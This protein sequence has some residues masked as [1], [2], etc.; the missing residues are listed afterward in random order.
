MPR[1]AGGSAA[2]S[3]GDATARSDRSSAAS[4]VARADAGVTERPGPDSRPT[5]PVRGPRTA[6]PIA[7]N[8]RGG[9]GATI[10]KTGRSDLVP[11]C[12][13]S[14]AQCRQAR[15]GNC[16]LDSI[17]TK[18]R[19]DLLLHTRQWHGIRPSLDRGSPGRTR[20]R[21]DRH[22]RAPER[23]RRVHADQLGRPRHGVG[24]NNPGGEL[25]M[26]IRVIL[27]DDHLLVRQG[28]R[29]VLEKEHI[30]V[31]GEASD[32]LEA[33][34]MIQQLLPEIAVLDLDMPGLDGLSV[35]REAARVSPQT[36]AIILTR[37]MEEPYAVKTQASTDLVAAIRHVDRGEVYLSLKISNAVVRAFLTNPDAPNGK[38]SLRERQVLQLVGEGH[39]TKKIAALLGISTKTADTHRTK[40]MEKLDI[41]QTAGLVRYAIRNGLIEP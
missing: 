24:D 3:Q 28:L 6:F 34:R 37:H 30:E 18:S 7:N 13:G 31:L 20:L 5:V 41:H 22:A 4:I 1:G 15:P 40:V 16:G 26:P 23:R 35:L 36:R 2:Y 10:S 32:G 14:V 12:Q 9:A 8:H 29:L 33:I 25:K 17:S 38:L 39:S 11:C 19:F 21:F 27:A